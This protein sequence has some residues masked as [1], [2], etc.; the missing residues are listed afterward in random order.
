ME[1][2]IL[3]K[4]GFSNILPTATPTG[5]NSAASMSSSKAGAVETG[6][7]VG[8]GVMAAVGAAGLGLLAVL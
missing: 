2:S 5:A 8:M 1:N 7:P 4:N 6:R 3:T